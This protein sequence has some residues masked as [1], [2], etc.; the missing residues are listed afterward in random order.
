MMADNPVVYDSVVAASND[1]S[2][3]TTHDRSRWACDDRASS[4][5]DSGSSDR[6]CGGDACE[7]KAR[8]D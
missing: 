7:T 5:P 1:S 6:A 4:S 2:S 8:D 3:D